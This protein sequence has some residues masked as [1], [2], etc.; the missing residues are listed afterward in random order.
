MLADGTYDAFIVDAR[1]DDTTSA[2][3]I[4][5]LELTIVTGEHK[6]EVVSVS[7]RN[8]RVGELDLIGMPATITVVGGRPDVRVER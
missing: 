1:V 8:L 5:H 3:R 7:A 4:T 2:E 6:G